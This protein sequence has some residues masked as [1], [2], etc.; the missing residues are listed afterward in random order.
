MH[1]RLRLNLSLLLAASL[2]GLLAWLSRP[3]APIPLTS[4]DPDTIG[5]IGIS[6]ITGR[7]IELQRR[8]GRWYLGDRVADQARVSQLL[9]ICR[10]PSLMKF[11]APEALQPYGLDPARLRL[12]L[13]GES[14]AFGTTDPVNGWRYVHVGDRIH[15]IADGFY[16]HLNAPPDAWLESP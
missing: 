4:L 15:M 5:R 12:Q 1:R 11:P 3:P 9:G 2:L 8:Q 16:H 6:D 14:L 10:T 13:N 7:H